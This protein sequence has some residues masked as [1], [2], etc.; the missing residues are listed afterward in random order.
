MTAI[1]I[2]PAFAATVAE[3]V[4]AGKTPYLIVNADYAV[5]AYAT[6]NEA[7]AAKAKNNYEGKVV[8]ASDVKVEVVDLA[9]KAAKP[10]VEIVRAS[11]IESPCFVVWDTA[12]NMKG[13]RRK[14]VIAACIAKGVA[15]YTARTQYQ[16]WLTAKKNDE[17]AAKSAK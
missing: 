4:A 5:G 6:R 12:D 8:K 17:A 1:K 15:Y 11:T 2:T 3:L 10:A 7:R 16:L 14:D 9:A 13:A